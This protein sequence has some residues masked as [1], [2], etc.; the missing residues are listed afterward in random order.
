VQMGPALAPVLASVLQKPRTCDRLW[1]E[2]PE[3]ER[4]P[5]AEFRYASDPEDLRR[6]VEG[7]RFLGA[8]A[9][10][11]ALTAIIGGTLPSGLGDISDE[12]IASL[13]HA[14]VIS[15]FHASGTTR[16][17]PSGDPMAV[18]DPFCRMHGIE[19][20]RVA[21]ASVMP[22]IPRANTHLTCVVIGERVASWIRE[23]E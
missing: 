16:M 7:V 9:G 23:G 21:D 22:T 13:I 5:Q 11:P 17:G 2:G 3:P 10:H 8:V 6:L 20:L 1:I 14:S 19:G 18:V 15:I 12:A 4:P